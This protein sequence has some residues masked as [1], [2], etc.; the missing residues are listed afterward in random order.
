[1]LTPLCSQHLYSFFAASLCVPE[2]LVQIAWH[3]VDW[4]RWRWITWGRHA[5][6]LSSKRCCLISFPLNHSNWLRRILVPIVLSWWRHQY[7]ASPSWLLASCHIRQNHPGIKL[8]KFLLFYSGKKV[9]IAL[10]WPRCTVCSAL[11]WQPVLRTQ[12]MALKTNRASIKLMASTGFASIRLSCHLLA[13]QYQRVCTHQE[14]R[15]SF[16]WAEI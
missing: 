15:R 3:S 7:V 12:A 2:A 9:W 16:P 11:Y 14:I 1:M 10:L 6:C 8:E 4:A 5:C 13:C